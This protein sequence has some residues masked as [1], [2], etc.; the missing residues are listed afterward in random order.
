M[1]TASALAAI[2]AAG[3]TWAED[4][5]E[6]PLSAAVT[7]A[8][9]GYDVTPTGRRVRPRAACHHCGRDWAVSVNGHFREHRDND[10][11]SCPGSGTRPHGWDA[12]T[13][14]LTGR[15]FDILLGLAHGWTDKRIAGEL[16]IAAYTA[17][18]HVKV[19]FQ[20]LGAS[21]RAHAVAIG[22]ETGLLRNGDV[23]TTTT[24][25]PK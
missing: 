11:Q 6:G 21:N 24:T 5:D 25:E 19:L 14:D 1:I 23:T 4:P 7:N 8:L 10:R 18:T 20:A 16:H 3:Q 9:T 12:P 22:Y 17:K 13:P 15:Q 2:D